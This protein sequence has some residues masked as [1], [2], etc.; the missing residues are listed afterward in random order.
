M[1]DRPGLSHPGHQRKPNAKFLS[2][3][4]PTHPGY[5]STHNSSQTSVQPE[6]HTPLLFPQPGYQRVPE[7]PRRPGQRVAQ[8]SGW[9][10]T[11][12]CRKKKAITCACMTYGFNL[13]DRRPLKIISGM[14]KIILGNES[15]P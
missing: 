6:G 8:S 3:S 4:I 15:R 10:H 1:S 12:M 7:G 9:L 2:L 5:P 11:A 14:K 13:P